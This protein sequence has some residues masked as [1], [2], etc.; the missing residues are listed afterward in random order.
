LDL[1]DAKVFHLPN[2]QTLSHP[3][4]LRVLRQISMM[5]AR[6]PRIAKL[7]VSIFKANGIQPRDYKRQAEA[8]L[9]WVQNPKNVF[10]VNEPGE[11]LQDPIHT[12]KIGHGDCD[13]Q[14]LLLTCL[15]ESVGL[16]WKFVLS[17][18]NSAGQKVR[19]VEGETPDPTARWAHIYCMVGTPPFS[20]TEWWYCETTVIGVPLGWDVVSG[21]HSY[22]PEMV[23][24][25]GGKPQI[26]QV[27][28]A[29]SRFQPS[30]IPSGAVSP[31]YALAYGDLGYGDVDP[32]GAEIGG[33]LSAQTQEIVKKE[34][35]AETMKALHVAILTGVVVSVS[36]S[37]VMQWINGE[38][39]WKGAGHLFHRWGKATE[40]LATRSRLFASPFTP[41][42]F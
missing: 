33:Q 26:M 6:D 41:R 30:P 12:I 9:K 15:F 39:F 22:L 25:K 14:A 40:Q 1:G 8:L 11:R 28:P 38:G 35:S 7:A 24:S 16:P 21:D 31:A 10:Y 42:K 2:W 37:M 27:G 32:A 34:V 5:R 29:D 18:R 19:H 4:R 3:E 17:G 23:K 36:T 13:D 20:P